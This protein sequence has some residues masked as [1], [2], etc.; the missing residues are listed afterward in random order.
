MYQLTFN[1]PKYIFKTIYK[2]AILVLE[3]AQVKS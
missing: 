2:T 3:K 1:T